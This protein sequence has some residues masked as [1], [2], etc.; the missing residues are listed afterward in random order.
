M[1]IICTTIDCADPAVVADF[2]NAALGWGG[3]SVAPGGWGAPFGPPGRGAYL[4]TGRG[5]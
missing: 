3:V 1:E 5:W 2:W 4:R